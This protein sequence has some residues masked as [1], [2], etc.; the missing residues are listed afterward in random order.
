MHGVQQSAANK[1]A[2]EDHTRGPDEEF[3]EGTSDGK[4]EQLSGYSQEELLANRPP[5]TVDETHSSGNVCDRR[6][7]DND[8]SHDGDES[9]FFD[10]E[11]PGIQRKRVSESRKPICG[12][13]PLHKLAQGEG[14]E[15]DEEDI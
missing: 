1:G 14:D 10:V 15:L 3:A 12:E 2:W 7:I 11:W 9:V 13:N 4:S 6:G 5:N 8:V